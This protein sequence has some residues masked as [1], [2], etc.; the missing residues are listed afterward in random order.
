MVELLINQGGR[1]YRWYSGRRNHPAFRLLRG[2]AALGVLGISTWFIWKQ[3]SS[4]YAVISLADLSIDP[5][6]LLVS[7]LFVTA[8]T[9]LGAWEWL[10]LVNALGGDLHLAPGMSIHLTSNLFKYVPGFIWP[11]AGKAYLAS[12]HGV[13]ASIAV[14][15]IAFEFGIVYLTGVLVLL[16]SLP[17]SGIVSWPMGQRLAFQVGAILLAVVSIASIPHVGRRLARQFERTSVAQ[18]LKDRTNWT[19][20]AFVVGAVLATWYMLGFG[21]SILFSAVSP[22]DWQNM[23]RQTFALASALLL[24]QIVLFVPTGLGVREA[25]LVALLAVGDIAA[26]VVILAVV[27]RIEMM[28]GEVICALVAL[29]VSRFFAP[30]RADSGQNNTNG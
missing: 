28:V 9:A 7:W 29:T 17:F 4:G 8:A 12:R 15:S 23:L 30:R 25:A 24:G 27:F 2:L 20:V 1:L 13:P 19:Q 18:D 21:F 5:H 16:L 6:R 11:Y 3:M 14:L 10:L 22:G 26:L